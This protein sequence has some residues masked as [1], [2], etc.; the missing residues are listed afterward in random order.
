MMH[1]LIFDRVIAVTPSIARKYPTAKTRL[2]RNFPWS[3]EFRAVEGLPY[4][5]REPIA[6]YAGVLGARRGLREMSQAVELAAKEVPIKLLLA[7]W[8]Y[9]GAKEELLP[10]V[11]Y[12]FVEYKGRLDHSQIPGLLAQAKIGL[13]LMH[14]MANKLDALPVKLFEYMAAGLPVVIS[15]FPLWRQVVQSAECGLLVDPLNPAAVAEAL[16]WLLRHPAEAAAMGR[17]GQR[18]VTE[19]YNWERESQALITTYAELQSV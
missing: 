14:P 9:S 18:A 11:D 17:N 12:G 3:H 6:V 19:N 13:F 7:G 8:V 16:V 10:Q 1:A 5:Q 15:D 4:E 2:V